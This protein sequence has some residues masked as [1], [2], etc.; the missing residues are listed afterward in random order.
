MIKSNTRVYSSIIGLWVIVLALAFLASCKSEAVADEKSKP[1]IIYILADDL[2]YGDVSNYNPAGKIKT[3]NIDRLASEGMRFMDAH[4][5]SSVCTPTRYALLTG[6]YCWRTELPRGVMRGYGEALI[7]EDRVTVASML[8]DNGYTTGVVGK[9]HL[10]L[11]WVMKD[12]FRDSLTSKSVQRNENGVITQMNGDWVDFSKK[13]TDGPLDHGF[14]YSYILPASLDMEPYCYLE[15]DVLTEIPDQYTPGNELNSDSYATGA[16]WRAGKISKT[17]DF[18]DLLPNFINKARDFIA[19]NSKKKDPFFLYVP[20]AAPHS[21]WVPKDNYVGKSGAGE[22]G[23][24]VQMVDAEVGR[25][26]NSLEENGILENTMVVFTSDNG[27]FWKPDFIE[28]FDHKAAM[29]Y[30]GMKMDIHEGGHRVPFIVKWPGKVKAG[31]QSNF[32]TSLTNFIATTAEI[33]DINLDADTGG[34]SQSILPILLDDDSGLE[35]APVIHHS[36]KG[37]FAIRKG[38]WKLVE[39]RGSG[40]FSKPVIVEPQEGE[41]IGQL[42]NLESDSVERI[43]L[44]A[45]RPEIVNELLAELKRIKNQ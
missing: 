36:S 2:G 17:F 30:R 25:L 16:F 37:Y 31:S 7:E 40:G 8:K 9:W 32:T 20:L 24:F 27:P 44:Y 6:R 10:G 33:L 18:Y 12:A 39:G 38:P 34:D 11:D 23:D 26:L 4:T 3:P 35:A 41:P 5:P 1:N 28:R 43:N 22:Y 29:D 14:D 13:P 21:P 42:Y 15:N 19:I 45:E